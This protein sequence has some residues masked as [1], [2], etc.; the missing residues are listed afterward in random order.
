MMQNN[1]EE[2]LVN[3]D[4][5]KKFELEKSNELM[6]D[7]PYTVKIIPTHSDPFELQVC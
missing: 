4:S 1:K 3:G 2:C 7:T 5:V 6:D